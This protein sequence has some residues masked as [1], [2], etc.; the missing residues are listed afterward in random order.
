MGAHRRRRPSRAGA[1]A[2]IGIGALVLL[3]ATALVASPLP[4][5]VLLRVPEGTPPERGW[6]VI[7]LLHGYGVTKE[8]FDALADACARE[9]VAAI[10]LDAPRLLGEGTR[11]WGRSSVRTHRYLGAQLDSLRTDSRLDLS[12]PHLGGFSQGAAHALALVIEHPED[13][14]GILAISP[15]GPALPDAWNG[16]AH[17]HPLFL[18]Y[19]ER[20]RDGIRD[21][22]RAARRL[23]ESSGR[24]V[25]VHAHRGGHHF[26][27]DWSRVLGRAVTYLVDASEGDD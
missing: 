6:P 10:A 12:R 5:T 8:D 1:A 25:R 11:S 18:M 22:A 24:A 23:W 16:D 3:V 27:D 2:R 26:P 21:T 13:Y 15:A 4:P 7:V 9:G 20:E 17:P 14:A 19:G